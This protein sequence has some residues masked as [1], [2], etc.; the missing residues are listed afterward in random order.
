MR[1]AERFQAAQARAADERRA[2]CESCVAAAMLDRALLLEMQDGGA[3]TQ[4]SLL[5]MGMQRR[6]PSQL[7]S[8]FSEASR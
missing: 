6:S 3:E 4:E 7:S 8:D 2:G 1:S 5:G